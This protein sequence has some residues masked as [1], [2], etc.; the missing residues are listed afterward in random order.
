MK[1]ETR[2]LIVNTASDLFYKNG[3]NLIGINKIIEEA[4]IAKAT[5]YSHFKSKEDLCIAY[6]E[7]KDEELLKK[8]QSFCESKPAGNDRLLAVLEFLMLFFEQGDFNG[9]WCIRTVAEIPRDNEEISQTIRNNKKQFLNF[10]TQLVKTN[11][12]DLKE[13]EQKTLAR[14]IYLLYEGAVSES[15]LQGDAWPIEENIRLL[16]I[17]LQSVV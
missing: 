11:R 6:L 15:H 7:A 9:C 14:Q 10:I 12:T 16:K 3:Y 8:L 5:L 17:I 2:N 1:S 4:G 13:D